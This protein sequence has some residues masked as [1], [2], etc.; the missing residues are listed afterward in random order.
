MFMRRKEKE[1]TTLVD[2]ENR[3]AP[4]DASVP[5]T[6]EF[7]AYRN[8]MLRLREGAQQ[9]AAQTPEISDGQ[10]GAFLAGIR[11][12]IEQPAP[13]HAKGMWA[14]ASLVAA[15]LVLVLSLLVIF[16]QPN[17]PVQA[18]EVESAHT[19]LDGVSVNCYDSP[20]GTTTVWVT[21]PESDLW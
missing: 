1:M 16:H 17:K 20:Q 6:P 11:E 14:T 9:A 4:A 18:T 12:G 3:Y 10:M 7:Q 13:R 19:E 21:M 2:G 15:A 8:D 5:K